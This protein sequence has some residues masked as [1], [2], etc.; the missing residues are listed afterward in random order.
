MRCEAIK[1][2]RPERDTVKF[3]KISLVMGKECS[4]N[5]HQEATAGPGEM[6]VAQPAEERSGSRY[7]FEEVNS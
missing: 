4:Q 3:H 6:A 1:C 7:T 5:S 2:L